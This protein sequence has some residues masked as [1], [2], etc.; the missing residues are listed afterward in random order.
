MLYA[1]DVYRLTDELGAGANREPSSPPIEMLP[2]QGP[3]IDYIRELTGQV[4]FL[5]RRIGEMEAQVK[6]LPSP[7]EHRTVGYSAH[8]PD[9][10]ERNQERKH[11]VEVVGQNSHSS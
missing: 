2:D 4:A 10:R 9:N 7:E 1:E 3:L 8:A 11:H 6:M 5:S